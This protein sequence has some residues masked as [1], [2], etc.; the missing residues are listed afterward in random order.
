MSYYEKLKLGSFCHIDD[1]LELL[2]QLVPNTAVIAELVSAN[3]PQAE[4][5]RKAVQAAANAIGQE[6]IV[7]EAG[8]DRDIESAFA[9]FTQHGVSFCVDVPY[10]P[11]RQKLSRI[12]HPAPRVF[13]RSKATCAAG[14]VALPGSKATS[15]AKGSHRNLGGLGSGRQRRVSR[16]V[17]PLE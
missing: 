3:L 12:C 17:P 10:R 11:P 13:I 5:E 15:R 16:T 8:S 14:A 4:S 7:I 6:L 1:P 9:T 2:R